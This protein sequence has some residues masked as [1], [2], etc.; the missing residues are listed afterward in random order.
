M[1]RPHPPKHRRFTD[2]HHVYPQL[3]LLGR[4]RASVVRRAWNV[5]SNTHQERLGGATGERC[6][7]VV[8]A[9]RPTDLVRTGDRSQGPSEVYGRWCATC[10]CALPTGIQLRR[11]SFKG[12]GRRRLMV[13]QDCGGS[14]KASAESSSACDLVTDVTPSE[15]GACVRYRSQASSKSR[16]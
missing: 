16:R 10:R 9:P 15:G 8:S 7:G 4:N 3:A 2:S 11:E 6:G 13:T 14:M 12:G 1:S 5:L